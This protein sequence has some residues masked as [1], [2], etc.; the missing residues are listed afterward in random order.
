MLDGAG[1]SGGSRG[2]R[3]SRG[4]AGRRAA[5]PA[6][7]EARRPATPRLARTTIGTD[8]TGAQRAA[9]PLIR[10]RTADAQFDVTMMSPLPAD[11]RKT[12]RRPSGITS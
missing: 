10:E 3:A 5:A 2:R 1:A 9:E 11:S 6:G 4:V 8:H 12:N 7:V